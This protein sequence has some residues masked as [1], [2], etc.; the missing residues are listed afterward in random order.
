MAQI[1][2]CELRS[3]P[4]F[5]GVLRGSTDKCPKEC[6]RSAFGQ[7]APFRAVFGTLR[8][9]RQKAVQKYSLGTFWPGPLH[10]PVNG[11]CNR[12]CKRG[13][14]GVVARVLSPLR[15]LR[16]KGT[17]I[18]EPRFSPP[19]DMRFF[20]RETGNMAILKFNPPPPEDMAMFSVSHAE[21]SHVTANRRKSGFTNWC[22]F[23]H[24]GR[25][26]ATWGISQRQHG[27]IA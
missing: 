2:L 13:C 22:A 26:R 16:P 8:A 15:T 4:P 24:Q 1:C 10:A 9:R 27:N 12:K 18:C 23:G 5:T 3:R 11:S 17:L 7:T 20:P 6:P 25:Y 19:F 21:K 14:Q